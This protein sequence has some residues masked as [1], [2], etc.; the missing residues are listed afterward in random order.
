MNYYCGALLMIMFLASCERKQEAART[1]FKQ[2]KSSKQIQKEEQGQTSQGFE[3]IIN[4][5]D[6]GRENMSNQQIIDLL[7]GVDQTQISTE[8][9][10]NLLWKY[11]PSRAGD[12]RS[13]TVVDAISNILLSQYKDGVV[14]DHLTGIIDQLPYGTDNNAIRYRLIEK[15]SSKESLQIFE[16]ISTIEDEKNKRKALSLFK[17]SFASSLTALSDQELQNIL[18]KKGSDELAVI[19]NSGIVGELGD[20]GLFDTS[21][22]REINSSELNSGLTKRAYFAWSKSFSTE[23]MPI[24]EDLVNCPAT[25]KLQVYRNLVSFLKKEEWT[26]KQRIDW[27]EENIPAQDIIGASTRSFELELAQDYSNMQIVVRGIEDLAVQKK[28]LENLTRRL[29]NPSYD[30]IIPN[31]SSLLDSAKSLSGELEK[32]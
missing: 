4:K 26:S 15:L 3:D 32:E 30:S 22:L 31:R 8:D 27:I 2:P 16:W 19:T 24:K 11:W 25:A 9:Y 29:K 14:V 23:Q 10:V 20:R 17:D 5:L 21:S 6:V 18:N 28:L 13:V 12:N 7:K 1:D